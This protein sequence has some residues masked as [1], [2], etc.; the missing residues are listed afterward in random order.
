MVRQPLQRSRAQQVIPGPGA[1]QLQP[2]RAKGRDV[3]RMHA[4]G[5]RHLPRAVQVRAQQPGD[6]RVSG[7]CGRDADV[8]RCA[9]HVPRSPA[10]CHD[11]LGRVLVRSQQR[12]GQLDENGPTN[13]VVDSPALANI[14]FTY[15]KGTNDTVQANLGFT[16]GPV[17]PVPEPATMG[18]L[19]AGLIGAGL[20][21]R[22]C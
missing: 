17:V 21:R 7:V 3:Q 8:F 15:S 20:L 5:G 1:P 11:S 22:R 6:A 9:G 10:F 16:A 12:A 2:R 19:G 4:A 13:T 18:L 14:R